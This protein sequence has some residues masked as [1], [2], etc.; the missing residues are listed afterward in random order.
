MSNM[1]KVR[2]KGFGW[3]IYSSDLP[4]SP[5]KS[6]SVFRSGLRDS[7][8]PLDRKSNSDHGT[9][10]PP[11]SNLHPELTALHEHTRATQTP[12]LKTQTSTAAEQ[13]PAERHVLDASKSSPRADGVDKTRT[14]TK[15]P[16]LKPQQPTQAARP[17]EPPFIG[18]TYMSEDIP[19]QT[20]S[21]IWA[22]FHS[23]PEEI[24]SLQ[25]ILNDS[26]VLLFNLNKRIKS[27][28]KLSLYV[29]AVRWL[30]FFLFPVYMILFWI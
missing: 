6:C 27:W 26:V 18:D 29:A 4:G 20:V 14:S 2:E 5:P 25:H 28:S 24:Q 23:H 9:R 8:E 1:L 19:P 22:E 15:G 13:R 17:T 10:P 7:E 11:A 16:T 30:N 21:S 12:T 3:F